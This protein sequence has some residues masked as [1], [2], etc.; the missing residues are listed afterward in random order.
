VED[1]K[2]PKGSL[3]SFALHEKN[4]ETTTSLSA[5][6]HLLQ[7]KNYA[8]NDNKLHGLLSFSSTKKQQ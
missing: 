7:L 3:L 6:H 4:Q 1:D 5:L 2:E 8:E